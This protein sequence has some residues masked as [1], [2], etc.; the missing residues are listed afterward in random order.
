MQGLGFKLQPPPKTKFK[1]S[2]LNGSKYSVSGY[3]NSF[4]Y[5]L[6]I[7]LVIKLSFIGII[8]IKHFVGHKQLDMLFGHKG[9]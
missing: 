9:T 7:I 3:F 8:Q 1:H 2:D 5:F 4:F 6:P